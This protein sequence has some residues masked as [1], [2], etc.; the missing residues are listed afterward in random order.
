MAERGWD[1]LGEDLADFRGR[2]AE[3]EAVRGLPPDRL[4][5]SLEAALIELRYA[6]DHLWPRYEEL[7]RR[8]RSGGGTGRQEEQ[9]LRVLFQ[10]LPLPVALLDREGTVRRLNHAGAQL[11][12]V[13]A[14]YATGRPLAGFVDPADRAA[15]RSQAAAVARGDGDRSIVVGLQVPGESGRPPGHWQLTLAALRP[16]GE[17]RNAVLTVF[18][19]EGRRGAPVSG[20]AAP[21]AEEGALRHE[22]SAATREAVLLDVLDEATTALLSVRSAAPGEVLGAVARALRGTVA[23]WVIADAVDE[24]GALRRC[25]V[26]RP[27]GEDA[28]GPAGAMEAQDPASC[29]V[30]VEAASGG[31]VTVRVRPEDAGC[32]GRDAQGRAMLTRAGVL[33]LVCLP[34]C[35]PP[36]SAG[37]AVSAVLTLFRSGGRRSGAAAPGPF[38]MPEAG[39]LERVAR[40]TALVLG[41]PVTPPP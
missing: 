18:Q 7:V 29:P 35:R 10:R 9:L 22:L 36:G 6:A 1:E 28:D 32:F 24:G 30:V 3:L 13:G 33:S 16:P 21:G 17:T 41:G 27:P 11:L 38:S 37:P 34:V 4:A 15:L 19:T 14:G 26:V 31:V 12:G 8:T 25:A 39:V 2:V 5:R 20:R 40:H 23:D